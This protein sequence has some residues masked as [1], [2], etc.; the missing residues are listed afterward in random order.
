MHSASS[1]QTNVRV[2]SLPGKDSTTQYVPLFCSGLEEAGAEIVPA[3]PGTIL[4]LRFDIISI[5]FPAHFIAERSL[6]YAL[7]RSSLTLLFFIVATKVWRR[8]IVYTVHDVVPFEPRAEWLLWPFLRT[9]HR[10]TSGYMFLSETSRREFIERFPEER[11]K[12]FIRVDHCS[13]PVS[14]SDPAADAA[15]RGKLMGPLSQTFVVGFLGSI[16]PYKGIETLT[17]LPLELDCGTPVSL[18]VAGR[19]NAKRRPAV[20]AVLEQVQVPLVRLDQSLSDAELGSLVRA[21]DVVILPYTKGWNS[22]MVMLVLSLTGRLL[23]A[24]RPIFEELEAELGPPWVYVFGNS[25]RERADQ[26][27]SRLSA[28]NREPVTP[29][30]QARLTAFT[31]ARTPDAGGRSL[32]QFYRDLL[33]SRR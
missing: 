11:K 18:L 24:D 27:K 4:G 12:P 3:T 6:W 28:I 8:K 25:P 9:M 29:D 26:L 13:F 20:D 17:A 33:Q 22:G 32:L 10:L 31:S 5:H 2:L 21:V 30:D 14:A 19:A 15:L 7:I 23:L 16:K 1:H